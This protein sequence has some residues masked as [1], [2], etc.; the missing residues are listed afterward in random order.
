MRFLLDIHEVVSHGKLVVSHEVIP[1]AFSCLLCIF[2]LFLV[3]AFPRLD[4]ILNCSF[5]LVSKTV[6][7]IIKDLSS[8]F[9]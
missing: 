2:D 1:S 5:D 8:C 4:Q 3:L 9:K 7:C 6:V